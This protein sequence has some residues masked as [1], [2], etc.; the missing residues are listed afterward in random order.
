M[1]PPI[2]G[3]ILFVS[4]NLNYS[5]QQGIRQAFLSTTC[6][7]CPS[8]SPLLQFAAHFGPPVTF[9]S[10]QN[11]KQSAAPFPSQ[12]FIPT[13]SELF[14]IQEFRRTGDGLTAPEASACPLQRRHRHIKSRSIP[15][16]ALTLRFFPIPILDVYAV[17]MLW[18]SVRRPVQIIRS[19]QRRSLPFCSSPGKWAVCAKPQPCSAPAIH[20]C[21]GFMAA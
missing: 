1:I 6:A 12:A 20:C 7:I 5:I 3:W 2:S 21:R 4:G 18:D 15:A 14:Y 19:S 10:F 9:S 8:F 16:P 11:L 13:F 17:H